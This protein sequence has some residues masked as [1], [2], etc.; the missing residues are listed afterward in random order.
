MHFQSADHSRVFS[1]STTRQNSPNT[2]MEKLDNSYS[3]NGTGRS[4]FSDAERHMRS[5]K[6]PIIIVVGFPIELSF[7][8]GCIRVWQIV[9]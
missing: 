9:S 7:I 8:L 3:K 4:E 2:K 1:V 6:L 5:K